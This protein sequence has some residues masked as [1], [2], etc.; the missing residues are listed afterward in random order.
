[1]LSNGDLSFHGPLLTSASATPSPGWGPK[2]SKI[3]R[4]PARITGLFV[5]K[6]R[7]RPNGN[8]VSME[9]TADG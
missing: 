4:A 3:V 7:Q 8:P 1:M 2:I 5:L 6:N 9:A